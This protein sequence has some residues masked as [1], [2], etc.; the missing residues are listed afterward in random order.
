MTILL[1]VG[2]LG[3]QIEKSS[4]WFESGDEELDVYTFEILDEIL[5]DG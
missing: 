2:V 4:N 3:S 1:L 5:N